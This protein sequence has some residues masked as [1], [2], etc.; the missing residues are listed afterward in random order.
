MFQCLHNSVGQQPQQLQINPNQLL[1]KPDLFTLLTTCTL[2]FH[3]MYTTLSI[4]H[5][6]TNTT[7]THTNTHTYTQ[8]TLQR[9]LHA[10]PTIHPEHMIPDFMPHPPLT[11]STSCHTHHSPWGRDTRPR[12]PQSQHE[13]PCSCPWLPSGSTS[14]RGD[15]TRDCR[16]RNRSSKVI[17]T[18]TSAWRENK[19]RSF[20]GSGISYMECTCASWFMGAVVQYSLTCTSSHVDC[21]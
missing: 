15:E 18:C 17:S 9:R 3:H 16:G 5:K 2:H 21:M 6:H 1:Y 19:P 10:T 7:D 20:Y 8:S 13:S 11:L 14:A 12:C 4:T